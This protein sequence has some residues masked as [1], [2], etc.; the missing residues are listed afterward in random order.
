MVA[1]SISLYAF[2][3][4]PGK[5]V[6][7]ALGLAFILYLAYLYFYIKKDN[8]LFKYAI[9][10]F[11]SLSK[12]YIPIFPE[13]I[14][15]IVLVTLIYFVLSKKE[16]STKALII[17]SAI[18]LIY[19]FISS[20][21]LIAIY[22]KVLSY[23]A[24]GSTDSSLHFYSVLQTVSEATG[25][26]FFN[27]PNS[28]SLR[29]IG[30]IVGFFIFLAGYLLLIYK[31]KEFL[32]AL[33]L[34]GIGIFAHWG[35]LRFTVYAVPIAAL[36]SIYLLCFISTSISNKLARVAFL[37]V[38]S[39]ALIYPNINH[40]KEYNPGTVF[41]NYELKDLAKLKKISTPNDYTFAWWD[42]GYP[43]WY[44]T[45]TNTLL[46][47]SKHNNDNYIFS[48]MMLSDSPK[49]AANFAKLTI[50]YYTKLIDTNKASSPIP[51]ELK[52]VDK[53]GKEYINI[54]HD[55]IINTILKVGQ[56]DQKDPDEFLQKL[57]KSNLDNI[58]LNRDIYLYAPYSMS[59]IFLTI[60]KFGNIDLTTGKKEREIWFYPS[61]AKSTKGANI[62][63]SNGIVFN[64]KQGY[65]LLNGNKIPTSY[66]ITTA[67][68][69]N[70]DIQIE[71]IRYKGGSKVVLFNQNTKQFIIMD[72]QTFKSNYVQ[73][74]LLGLYD[75]KLFELVVKSPYSRVYK[76]K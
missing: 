31:H 64:Y 22:N 25:I 17:S 6:A 39:A 19:F 12:F 30:S 51:N 50:S 4:L 47:G 44:F 14:L 57:E 5:T 26:P 74:F 21:A 65:L 55:P 7:Y 66:F 15:K 75:K 53:D 23:T 38:A 67:I 68:T 70:G 24:S 46:D 63:F 18:L 9:L 11:V 43:L 32:I 69:K 54:P 8:I 61:Y 28:V 40:T 33:P 59:R 36:S 2:M 71:P 72:N 62:I 56:K 42:Y 48:K 41:L 16:F 45:Q 27:S 60:S 73:M 10:L 3:Y 35:G 37:A 34:V 13:T 52:M 58:K 1:L 49:F 76:I 20:N 29:I